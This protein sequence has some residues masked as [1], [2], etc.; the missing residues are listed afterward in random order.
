MAYSTSSHPL[1]LHSFRVRNDIDMKSTKTRTD[2][3][4][5]IQLLEDRKLRAGLVGPLSQASDVAAVSKEYDPVA[6]LNYAHDVLGLT[7]A[8]QTVVVIDSG[9]A[10]DHYALGGGFGSDYR[11]V[12]GWDFAEN[13]ADPYDDGPL[14]YHG[15]H[16]AGIVASDDADVEG[17]A[18]EADLV[19]LRVFDDAGRCDF[20]WIESALAWVH[21]NQDTFE[22]PITTV[23]L[24]LGSG[25][26]IQEAPEW[27]VLEDEFESLVDDGIFVSVAAGNG[28]R[29]YGVAGLDYPAAS[30]NVVPVSSVN[31]AGELSDFSQRNERSLAV[32]GELVNS[33]VPDYLYSFDGVTDDFSES[34]GTSMASPYLAGASML[35]REALESAGSTDI[36]QGDIYD[37]LYDNADTIF[38]SAT[39]ANYQRV[40]LRATLDSIVEHRRIESA[41]SKVAG[42]ESLGT[43]E[44]RTFDASELTTMA[45]HWFEFNA[46]ESGFM[47]LD[48]S[49]AASHEI[50]VQQGRDRIDE[51]VTGDASEVERFFEV[52]EGETY[53][54]Y[55]PPSVDLVSIQQ[56]VTFDGDTL[57]VH[58]DR[59]DGRVAVSV[60]DDLVVVAGNDQTRLETGGR[61]D[62][63]DTETTIVERTER[64]LSFR[65]ATSEVVDVTLVNSHLSPNSLEDVGGGLTK[66]EA[67]QKDL[68]H[69]AAIDVGW[70]IV[71]ANA[72]TLLSEDAADEMFAGDTPSNDTTIKAIPSDRL[73]E[74]YSHRDILVADGGDAAE[75]TFH[76]ALEDDFASI[77]QVLSE[78]IG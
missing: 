4:L 47:V 7:G 20:E 44:T 64:G 30:P 27:S 42:V 5:D 11:V 23:N 71:Q 63:V 70:G 1:V 60:G 61:L 78:S 36:S 39:Q 73:D 76:I 33:T 49:G 9:I 58:G 57:D 43:V 24:S 15:T 46:A 26:N 66:T 72:A 59:S 18:P 10:Y 68:P 34:S 28:F 53:R 41:L 54:L 52:S 37:L 35:V 12:G 32:P 21:E 16:V 14:G 51:P 48:G 77:D 45:G 22:H 6:D 56:V 31:G 8:G 29:Q 17:V 25:E 74:F 13:D 50:E 65:I 75:S 38:D 40:N 67:P 2:V 19:A 62:R 3:T 55:V 69:A